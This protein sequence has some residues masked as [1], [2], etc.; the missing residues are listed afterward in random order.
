[1]A[2][3]NGK[4]RLRGALT[5][6]G[7]V[8]IVVAI[9]FTVTSLSPKDSAD[10]DLQ[11]KKTPSITKETNSTDSATETKTDTT[12]DQPAIDPELVS[13]VTVEPMSIVVSY[14][15]G[16]GGF[17]YEVL[18]TP[19][20]SKYVQLS[21][22]RLAGTKCTNDVGVFA[23]IIDSPTEDEGTT[24]AKQVTVDGM[25]YGLSLSDPTCTSDPALLKQYQDAF[26]E[27]FT[28][29]KKM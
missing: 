3:T 4:K 1:M 21:S 14:L 6:L 5:M 8:L 9:A 13:T 23:S 15:K 18:R 22:P 10:S 20:G 24:L 19:D 27:P 26:I 12:T 11:T 17:D 16:V 28:L 2:K 25:T 29:L 7:I